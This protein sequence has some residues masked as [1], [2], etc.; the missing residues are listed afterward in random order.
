M[1]LLIDCPSGHRLKVPRKRAGHHVRCP[2]CN[3]STFVP[4][5]AGA[6]SLATGSSTSASEVI[7]SQSSEEIPESTGRQGSGVTPD[8][9]EARV[10]TPAETGRPS[11]SACPRPA[12]PSPKGSNQEELDGREHYEPFPV[13]SVGDHAVRPRAIA[14]AGTRQHDE[15]LWSI[16]GLGLAMMAMA[17]FSAIPAVR[18]LSAAGDKVTTDGWSHIVLLIALI[19]LSLAVYAMQLRDWSATWICALGTT[20]VAA[21]Y[22]AGLAMCML[23]TQDNA[24]VQRLGLGDEKFHGTAGRWCFLVLCVGLILAYCCGRFSL[25]CRRIDQRMAESCTGSS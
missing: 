12:S 4:P 23:A 6:A 16:L 18:E 24:L 25:S 8:S 5:L 21:F 1:P 13:I 22:A 2:V 20:G 14:N 11:R 3:Q 17:A 7:G 15:R 9:A 10:S 19:Q